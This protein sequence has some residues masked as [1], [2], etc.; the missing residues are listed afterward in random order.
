MGDMEYTYTEIDILDKSYEIIKMEKIGKETAVYL[1]INIVLFNSGN[2]SSG[3]MTVCIWDTSDEIK[4]YRNGSIPAKTTRSYVFGDKADWMVVGLKEHTI[5]IQYY[6]TNLSKRTNLNSGEETL[7]ILLYKPDKS[8]S[9]PG[10]EMILLIGVIIILL[11][12]K[13]YVENNCS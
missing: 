6:P 10:F 8:S 5:R 13:K 1:N 7:T 4:T 11:Q 2:L 12:Y 3:D 9:T